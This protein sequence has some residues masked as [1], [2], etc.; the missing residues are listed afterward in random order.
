MVMYH[1]TMTVL[2]MW[3]L[4]LFSLF[5]NENFFT[6]VIVFVSGFPFVKQGEH[7]LLE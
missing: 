1:I 4:L 3:P 2:V 7:F 5:L 6:I